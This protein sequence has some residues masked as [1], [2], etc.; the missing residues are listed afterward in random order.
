MLAMLG[1]PPPLAASRDQEARGARS[2]PLIYPL[3][4]PA[5]PRTCVLQPP[6]RAPGVS[7]ALTAKVHSAP[8]HRDSAPFSLPALHATKC[9]WEGASISDTAPHMPLALHMRVLPLPHA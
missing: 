8:P 6:L 7:A 1:I 9:P 2:H 5:S 3:R 4:T